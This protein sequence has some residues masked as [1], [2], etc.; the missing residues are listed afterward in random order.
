MLFC[1][2]SGQ[3]YHFLELG[4]T[5]SPSFKMQKPIV[6][7]RRRERETDRQTER[8]TQR[9]TNRKNKGKYQWIHVV[10]TILG[11]LNWATHLA[12]LVVVAV[13]GFLVDFN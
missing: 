13:F 12:S 8:D 6:T 9:Q 2:I 11:S 1:S 3:K 5:D 10:V 4:R 7:V